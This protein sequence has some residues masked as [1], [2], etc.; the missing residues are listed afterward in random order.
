MCICDLEFTSRC[1]SFAVTMEEV[2]NG[3]SPAVEKLQLETE[4]DGPGDEG[5]AWGLHSSIASTIGHMPVE[6]YSLHYNMQHPRRGKALIFNHEIFDTPSL[7]PRTGTNVD[8]QNLQECLLALGFE[9]CLHKDLRWKE[10]EYIIEKVSSDDHS[11]ADCLM[12]FV[13]THGEE[14]TLFAKD[15]P[16]KP[17]R[18]WIPFTA[19]RLAKGI[20]SMVELFYGEP[21]LMALG[22]CLIKSQRFYS[23][24]NTQKGSWFMQ[25][26]VDLLH[27]QSANYD[28]LT[29][30][31][32]VSQ[33]VAIDFESKS[34]TPHMHGQKQI[35][36]IT[37]MLTRLVLFTP[38]EA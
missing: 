20:V 32:L 24:R 29:L 8:S 26:L 5:D 11:D 22:D 13:L 33:R 21:K 28:L 19:D 35:P 12:L 15:M 27:T 37:S 1:S 18:L 10:I 38:K 34:N 17:E 16:Y 2:K 23:W 9:V 25:A 7:T 3:S 4:V 36:C 6:K 14:S 31:T 30:L